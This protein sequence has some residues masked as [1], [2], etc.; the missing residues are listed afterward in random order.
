MPRYFFRSNDEL[1]ATLRLCNDPGSWRQPVCR[2]RLESDSCGPAWLLDCREPLVGLPIQDVVVR[3]EGERVTVRLGE[4]S[5]D[6]RRCA[7][8]QLPNLFRAVPLVPRRVDRVPQVLYLL[9]ADAGQFVELARANLMLGNDR[10]ACAA[11]DDGR[12]VL[13]VE[14]MSAFLAEKWLDAEGIETLAP[15]TGESRLL[16]PLDS[17]WPLPDKLPLLPAGETELWLVSRAGEWR[18]FPAVLED[19][20]ER[21]AIRASDLGI[22]PLRPTDAP[23]ITVELRLVATERRDR[24]QL[25]WL[26]GSEREVLE[27]LFR[28]ASEAELN[29]LQMAALVDSGGRRCYVL[30]ER[31]GALTRLEPPLR[32]GR[33]YV[34][35]LADDLLYLPVGYGIEPLLSRRSLVETLGLADDHLTLID[36]DG[37]RLKVTQVPLAAL[38]PV[39]NLVNYAAAD[40]AE[41][42][43]ALDATVSLDL[44]LDLSEPAAMPPEPWWRRWLGRRR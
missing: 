16:L 14:G 5:S 19:I 6:W 21:I 24:P 15:S 20:Y 34:A 32:G 17:D 9:I 29:N 25:W 37:A 1:C 27:R 26:E 31:H 30:V 36:R 18:S 23:E 7:V 4:E 11:L 13:R 40:A 2:T 41:A 10:L 39:V 44:D 28:E 35:R 33:P 42:L 22:E 38:Q 3:S 8:D 43:A 12:V